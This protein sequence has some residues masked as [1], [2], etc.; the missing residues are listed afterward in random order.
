MRMHFAIAT[1]IIT[2][3]GSAFAQAGAL[4]A[5]PQAVALLQSAG[6][7]PAATASANSANSDGAFGPQL[8][9]QQAEQLAL[10]DNPGITVQHLLALAQRQV[11]RESRSN[12]MPQ[13]TG[14]I[15]A[16]DGYDGSRI[17]SGTEL[18]ASRLLRH[19]GAGVTASQL[20]TDFGRTRN[21]VASSQL[22]VAAAQSRELATREDIVLMTDDAFYNALQAQAVLRVAQ[23]TVQT[24]QATQKQIGQLTKN[25]LRSTLDQSFADVNVSQAKLLLLDAKNNA[26]AAMA[27]L[28][29]VLG[30]DHE[31]DYTLV[32]GAQAAPPPPPDADVLIAMALKQR[33]DLLALQQTSEAQRK[34]SRSQ[35]DQ[36][37]PSVSAVGTVGV[38]PIRDDNY[39][40]T[41]WDGAAEGNVNIPVFNGFLFNAQ[42]KETSLRAQATDANARRLRDTI[43]RDVRT[44]WTGAQNSFARIAVADQLLQQ[45]NLSLK[46]AQERYRLGLS[47]IVEL[48][49]AQLA[50]TQ[51]DIGHT[52]AEYR[53]RSAL[54]ALAFQTGQQP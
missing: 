50:Q 48:T 1:V 46:L 39:Y 23:Q 47:S 9:R 32:P 45:A 30:L 52:D 41:N 17:S 24:R 7:L 10:R 3:S 33:P 40:I 34:L 54:A 12:D 43:V 37:L 4:P 20:I 19:V 15:T 38:S 28:D 27:S 21:L 25:N 16:E 13:V 49:D 42:A 5:A 31:Q 8:T 35:W 36:L 22:Q 26:D 44:A 29:A 51:A 18:T 11:V 6:R 2:V 53:Y 14:S